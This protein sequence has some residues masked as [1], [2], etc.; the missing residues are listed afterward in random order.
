MEISK[1]KDPKQIIVTYLQDAIAVEKSFETRMEGF[2]K[3]EDDPTQGL[4]RQYAS[5]PVCGNEG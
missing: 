4:L 3:R 5:L 2:F 1:G